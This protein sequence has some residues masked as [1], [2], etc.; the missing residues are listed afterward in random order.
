MGGGVCEYVHPA[1]T[2]ADL[3]GTEKLW[4][5]VRRKSKLISLLVISPGSRP[6][7]NGDWYIAVASFAGEAE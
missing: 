7:R 2:R 5:K 4:H 6:G 3:A 1:Q